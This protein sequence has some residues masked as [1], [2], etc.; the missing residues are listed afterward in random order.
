MQH[1]R[2]SPSADSSRLKWDSQIV[3]PTTPSGSQWT[4]SHR[5]RTSHSSR[6]RSSR[7]RSIH[8]NLLLQTNLALCLQHT[9]LNRLSPM[10][11]RSTTQPFVL[12]YFGSNSA[13]WRWQMSIKVAKWTVIFSISASRITSFLV[14][15]VGQLPRWQLFELLPFFVHCLRIQNFLSNE[16][17]EQTCALDCCDSTNWT[18][19]FRNVVFIS[20]GSVDSKRFLVDS[21]PSTMRACFWILWL[22]CLFSHDLLGRSFVLSLQ[23]TAASM[24][25]SN[26]F[27][28]FLMVSLISPWSSIAHSC[29][30]LF[31]SCFWHA[32]PYFRL[33]I[34]RS[35]RCLN[36]C[37]PAPGPHISF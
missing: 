21:W 29:F 6:A 19:S 26:F 7:S 15:T 23:G 2:R 18:L 24:G 34:I 13:F 37:K 30:P 5:S 16:A 17:Q 22:R 11:T 20:F 28:A 31:L 33:Q 10:S 8:G 27:L 36:V 14:N 3:H 12:W 32:A 4:F 35:D 1:Y 9:S 25:I